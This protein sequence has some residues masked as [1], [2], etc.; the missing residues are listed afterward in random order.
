MRP[1]TDR[2]RSR[3]APTRTLIDRRAG[4][5]FVA[6]DSTSIGYGSRQQISYQ[7]RDERGWSSAGNYAS[8]P[9]GTV[10]VD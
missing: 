1:L 8:I 2:R 6:S 9:R 4:R 10:N 7:V 3:M 5:T